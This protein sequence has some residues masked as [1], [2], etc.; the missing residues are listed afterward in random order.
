MFTIFRTIH[1]Y[2]NYAV[3]Y[4]IRLYFILFF[5]LFVLSVSECVIMKIEWLQITKT[6]GK[7]RLAATKN[8]VA[9]ERTLR[10]WAKMRMWKYGKKEEI[11]LVRIGVQ[12]ADAP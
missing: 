8:A 1:T 9:V 5:P 7:A 6:V 10:D 4:A 11:D 12:S 3:H 2:E